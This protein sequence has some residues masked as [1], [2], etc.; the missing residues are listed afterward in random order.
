MSTRLMM[1][2]YRN[3]CDEV[4]RGLGSVGKLKILKLLM[5]KSDEVF[6]RYRIG[7]YVS[8]DPVSI[9]NDLKILVEIDWV[10]EFKA[11]HLSKYSINREKKKVKHL[12]DFFREIGYL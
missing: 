7:K 10:T 12:I 6:T 3:I 4:E 8:I 2:E 1:E 11:Q 9:R 5:Q